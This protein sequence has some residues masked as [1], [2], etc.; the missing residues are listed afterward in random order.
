[1]WEYVTQNVHTVTETQTL[2]DVVKLMGAGTFRH[3]P[4][5]DQ[6]GELI[7]IVS[8][9]DVRRVLPS[10]G[11]E[12]AD[13]DQFIDRTLVSEVMTRNPLTISPEADLRSVLHLILRYRV[14][15][16]PIVTNG[17]LV[18]IITITDLLR[19]FKDL[20][21]DVIIP[22]QQQ[23]VAPDVYLNSAPPKLITPI[24]LLIEP[25]DSLRKELLT[26]LSAAQFPVLSIP[27][28][29]ELSQIP[30]KAKP[31][32]ILLS[33][34]IDQFPIAS[35]TLIERY[36]SATLLPTS[37]DTSQA[38]KRPTT[39][40]LV[41]YLPCS[42]EHLLSTIREKTDYR[43][44][45]SEPQ[46]GASFPVDKTFSIDIEVDTRRR[47]LII[48]QDPLAR[49]ILNEQCTKLGCEVV[50]ASDGHEALSRMALEY[51]DLVTMELDLPFRS[52]FELLDFAQ[53]ND[54]IQ[55]R[56]VIISGKRRDE[57]IVEAF[58][59]GALDYLQKP[60]DTELL[61]KRL[62]QHLRDN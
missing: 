2:R 33:K 62:K 58:S 5:V 32:L 37:T 21:D 6:L 59:L 1:M 60:I 8:D 26:I 56:V 29:V 31:G 48:D 23:T 42:P 47:I 43:T 18:G 17:S 4:V 45:K 16:L 25:S 40:D 39:A 12:A 22:Q 51:F 10:P 28:M 34:N 20:L 61:F 9:R 55:T 36:P 52:G 7:G 50:E 15:A 19:A 46:S 14:G 35:E 13:V 57:E 3:V 44:N 38:N 30:E 54:A 53:R 11:C 27:S 41:L 49:R 24:I